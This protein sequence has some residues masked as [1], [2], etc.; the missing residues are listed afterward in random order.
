VRIATLTEKILRIR[1][2]LLK[3]YQD[4]DVKRTMS[5]CISKRQKAMKVLYRNDFPLYKHVC[6][7]LGIRCI[8]FAV[9]DTRDPGR[10]LNPQAVDGDRAKF[11]VRQRL[12]KGRNM[13]RSMVEPYT[14]RLIRYTRH[15]VEAL[16]VSHGKPKA[17]PQQVSRAWPYGV[18]E[19]RVAGT[20]IVHNPTAAGPGYRQQKGGGVGGPTPM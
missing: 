9:P 18:K 11:L 20:H 17:V 13:P 19:D 10:C 2:H 1:T 6:E 4:H 14:N 8:R 7:E 15:P 16:P 12:W 5:I 3:E